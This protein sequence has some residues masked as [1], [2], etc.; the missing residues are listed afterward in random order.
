MQKANEDV[1]MDEII[2]KLPKTNDKYYK[3]HVKSSNV[4]TL[5]TDKGQKEKDDLFASI[6]NIEKKS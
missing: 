6:F 5:K 3:D 1:V 4:F 2:D